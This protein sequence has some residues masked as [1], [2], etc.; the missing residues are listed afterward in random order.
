VPTSAWKEGVLL[1]AEAVL[2]LEL[3]SLTVFGPLKKNPQEL[4]VQNL[5]DCYFLP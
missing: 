4:F 1:F 2:L 5:E 3:F